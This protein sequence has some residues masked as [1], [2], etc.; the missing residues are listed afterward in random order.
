MVKAVKPTDVKLSP[1][2]WFL[3]VACSKCMTPIVLMPTKTEPSDTGEV[4]GYGKMRLSCPNP[5][6]G[7]KASYSKE[8][9]QKFQVPLLH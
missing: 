4:Q 6:C 2:D 8:Q 7:H 3:G 9:L 1:G 5:S